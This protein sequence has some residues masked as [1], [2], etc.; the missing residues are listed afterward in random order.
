MEM[1]KS[2]ARTHC[3]KSVPIQSFF[4]IE[5]FRT[6]VKYG[7]VRS[8]SLY[9]SRVRENKDQKKLNIWTLSRNDTILLILKI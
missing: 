2:T 5:F 1:G 9:S 8:K 4:R 3:V 6:Q 7:D